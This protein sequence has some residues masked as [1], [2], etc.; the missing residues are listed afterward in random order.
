[1]RRVRITEAG[2]ASAGGEEPVRPGPRR[3]TMSE[4]AAVLSVA[5]SA[6]PAWEERFG[7]PHPVHGPTGQRLYALDELVALRD[8]LES[9][10][11]VALAISKARDISGTEGQV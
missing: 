11:S 5:P 9:E 10:L 1:M 2:R 4:A 8:G 6:L 3:L 7:Y